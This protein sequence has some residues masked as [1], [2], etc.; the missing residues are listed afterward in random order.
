M[1]CT[2][3]V[4]ARALKTTCRQWDRLSPEVQR[5]ISSWTLF[6]H[7]TAHLIKDLEFTRHNEAD[8]VLYRP[9]RLH[10]GAAPY[11]YFLQFRVV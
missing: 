5:L 11:A 8:N 3:T 9:A 6:V 2:L 7:R 1:E 10:V 4:D